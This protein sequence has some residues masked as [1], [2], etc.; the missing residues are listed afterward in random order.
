MKREEN[1]IEQAGGSA[2]Q[3][4]SMAFYQPDPEIASNLGLPIG[5]FCSLSL[6]LSL[7]WGVSPS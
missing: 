4:G 1:E 7:R 6:S 3:V 5:P 2:A